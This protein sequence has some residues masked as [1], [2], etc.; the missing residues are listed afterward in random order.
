MKF[1]I[2]ILCKKYCWKELNANSQRTNL[3]IK[4]KG[5]ARDVMNSQSS[6]KEMFNVTNPKLPQEEEHE[7]ADKPTQQNTDSLYLAIPA[8]IPIV[9]W[10]LA[11]VLGRPHGP[12]GCDLGIAGYQCPR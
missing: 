8:P 7:A 5:L 9:R 4:P 2:E 3:A 12:L 6:L 10:P 11:L 1:A